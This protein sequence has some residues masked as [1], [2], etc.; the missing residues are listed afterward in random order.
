MTGQLAP[1]SPSVSPSPAWPFRT[2]RQADA[3]AETGTRPT[4]PGT[5]DGTWT[6]HDID[7]FLI[8]LHDLRH[9]NA[10]LALDAGVDLK[11]SDRLGHTVDLHT[12]VNR[13]VGHAA[14]AQIAAILGPGA[15]TL[16]SAFVAQPP[17]SDASE[18]ITVG[19]S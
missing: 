17:V 16:P 2:S 1:L 15:E 13:G 11:V 12:H 19:A 18:E 7:S 3:I 5:H 14:A 9:T 6:G 10:S 8:R 4:I